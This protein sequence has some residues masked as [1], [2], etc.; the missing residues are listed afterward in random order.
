MRSSNFGK[1]FDDWISKRWIQLNG[2]VV[3]PGKQ[4]LQKLNNAPSL[5]EKLLKLNLLKEKPGLKRE[6]VVG[7]ITS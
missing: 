3:T 5:N 6:T 4:V 2:H 7:I 1:N